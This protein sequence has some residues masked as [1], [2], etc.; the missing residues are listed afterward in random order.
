M[1]TFERKRPR[2]SL[3]LLLNNK[4]ACFV[5]PCPR[6]GWCLSGEN[7]TEKCYDP[8]IVVIE[9]E[10]SGTNAIFY[11]AEAITIRFSDPFGDADCAFE[12][13]SGSCITLWENLL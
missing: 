9:C 12:K 2:I 7:R 10:V 4:A 5:Q 1:V 6:A 13:A 8:K 3:S 11:L